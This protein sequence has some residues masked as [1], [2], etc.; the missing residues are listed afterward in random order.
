MPHPLLRSA[1]AI[2]STAVIMRCGRVCRPAHRHCRR[3]L[4]RHARAWRSTLIVGE[5]MGHCYIYQSSLP[6]AQDA[7]Q[8]IVRFFRENL[9]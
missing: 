8:A 7:Y 4:P 5:G 9:K 3:I 6:E 1:V 2:V